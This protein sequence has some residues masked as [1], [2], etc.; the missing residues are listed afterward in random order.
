MVM[1]S[2][3]VVESVNAVKENLTHPEK[4]AECIA[5]VENMIE[6]KKAHLWRADCGSCCGN[7]CSLVP[8]IDAEIEFL[9]NV[10]DALKVGDAKKA[11]SSLG[12]YA[13]FLEKH[14]EIEHPNYW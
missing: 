4:G 13:V 5:D 6:T 14:Y 2:R 11:A 3:E 12:D 10:L 7:V 9:Q 8:Q 1:I